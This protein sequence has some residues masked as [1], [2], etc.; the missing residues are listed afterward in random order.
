[1]PWCRWRLFQ[2]T[3][4]RTPPIFCNYPTLL[5]ARRGIFTGR[6]FPVAF[7][8][9]WSMSVFVF[10]I[11]AYIAHLCTPHNVTG[12]L[13]IFLCPRSNFLPHSLRKRLCAKRPLSALLYPVSTFLHVLEISR[14][15]YSHS[16]GH[17]RYYSSRLPVLTLSGLIW[18]R[19]PR[20]DR[21]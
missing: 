19:V 3:A 4:C 7:K 10:A 16:L 5:F 20:P 9:A 12:G 2:W 17:V 1:M 13:H 15:S 14:L 8:V 21:F 11:W 6:P 18:I